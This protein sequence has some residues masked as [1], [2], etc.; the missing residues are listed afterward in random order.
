[1]GQAEPLEGGNEF[2]QV[3]Y[4]DGT[5]TFYLG[6]YGKKKVAI[7]Q[8]DQ[9]GRSTREVLGKVQEGVKAK[10]VIAVGICYG[11]KEDKVKLGD[12]IVAKHIMDFRESRVNPDHTRTPRLV[13]DSTG[14]HLCNIF[15]RSVGFK[16]MRGATNYVEVKIGKLAS[17]TKLVD[18]QEEKDQILKQCSDVLGGEMEGAAIM[19]LA[20]GGNFEAIVVKA[21]A[22]YGNENKQLYVNWKIFAAVAST[23]YILYHLERTE[24]KGIPLL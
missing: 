11:M 17:D 10:Y 15:S 6:M 2:D 4:H 9:G 14:K 18:D 3:S 16:E 19:E 24:M 1:M 13:G 5:V 7:I 12:V 23:K 21:V 20:D 8:T 22:D